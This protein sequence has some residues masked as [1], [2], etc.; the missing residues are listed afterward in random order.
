MERLQPG[1]LL[2][3]YPRE[4]HGL[5]KRHSK[6]AMQAVSAA[7][8]GLEMD[9][10]GRPIPVADRLPEDRKKVRRASKSKAK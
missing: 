1:T 4:G 3:L 2:C 10:K 6:P 8:P 7:H 9:A 5:K